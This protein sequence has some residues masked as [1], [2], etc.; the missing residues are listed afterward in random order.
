MPP[1]PSN[2][3]PPEPLQTVARALGNVADV[4]DLDAAK[5]ASGY[6]TCVVLIDATKPDPFPSS[7]LIALKFPCGTVVGFILPPDSSDWGTSAMART[8]LGAMEFSDVALLLTPEEAAPV[9]TSL[10]QSPVPMNHLTSQAVPYPRVKFLAPF[11]SSTGD[12]LLALPPSVVGDSSPQALRLDAPASVLVGFSLG[13]E[14]AI[15]VASAVVMASCGNSLWNIPS[16]EAH[17]GVPGG[18]A[19]VCHKEVMRVIT[20]AARPPPTGDGEDSENSENIAALEKDYEEVF[21]PTEADG[22]EEE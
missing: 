19:L 10:L 14:P 5:E 11:D 21:M 22:E 20:L 17:P 18:L 4:M 8:F 12:L 15:D 16:S 6:S 2:A 3:C 7:D 9:L 1:L 13:P